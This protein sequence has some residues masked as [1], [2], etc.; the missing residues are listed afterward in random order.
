MSETP[1]TIVHLL[2][3]GEV[4][5]P[6]GVLYGRRDGYHLSDLGRQMAEKVADA[7]KA[8]GADFAGKLKARIEVERQ[9]PELP[10]GVVPAAQDLLQRQDRIQK[11]L[12]ARRPVLRFRA[13]FVVLDELFHAEALRPVRVVRVRDHVEV[14]HDRVVL[15]RRDRPDRDF[16]HRPSLPH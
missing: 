1:D 11:K 13:L 14:M 7:V 2:R 12:A 6:D 4:H 16:A 9:V 15:V 5:N 10:R 8:A 3:H